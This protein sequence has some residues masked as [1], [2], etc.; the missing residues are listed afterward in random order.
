MRKKLKKTGWLIIIIT[1][2]LSLCRKKIQCPLI[3]NPCIDE[4][5]H[6]L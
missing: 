3:T 6:V 2:L 1:P 5:G 4:L